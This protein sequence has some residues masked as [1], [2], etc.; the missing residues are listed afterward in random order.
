[1]KDRHVSEAV[2]RRLPKYYRQL[3]ELK[4]QGIERISSGELSVKMGLNASQIRQDFNCFGGF[5]QQ[6]YGYQVSSLLK[7]IGSIL[8]LD[9]RYKVILVGAGHIG[10]ALTSYSGFAR[11]GFDIVAAF[12]NDERLIGRQLDVATVRPIGE[13]AEFL[14]QNRVDIGIIATPKEVANE[15]CEL[16]T[17]G[18]VSAI[19]NFAPVDV[20]SENVIVENVH[21][22]DSLYV[23][24]FRLNQLRAED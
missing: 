7:E 15:I 20:S 4:K 17:K 23:L 8:G 21:L 13:I 22:S 14:T 18:G 3:Q 24:S 6:G 1:M 5:G 11:Q 10:Q 16:L 12:D 9:Q 2:I 19:W